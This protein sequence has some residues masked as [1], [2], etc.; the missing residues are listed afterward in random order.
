M[1]A[2]ELSVEKTIGTSRSRRRAV[3]WS[4]VAIASISGVVFLA[5]RIQGDLVAGRAARLAR[6]AISAGRH[7]E[8]REPLARWLRAQP[9]NAEAHALLAQV[10]LEEGDLAKVTDELNRARRWATRRPTSSG[11][12]RSPWPGLAGSPRQSRSSCGST[13]RRS[14]P[15]QTSMRR[16]RGFT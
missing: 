6:L 4:A 10:A 11:F 12:T 13:N 14:S 9:G 1:V 5:F 2:N 15:I 7:R 3:V 16:W 8:A